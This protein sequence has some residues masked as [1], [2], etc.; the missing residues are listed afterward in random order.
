[1]GCKMERLIMAAHAQDAGRGEN[2]LRK[3]V[4]P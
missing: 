1:M 4:Y 2:D 3:L